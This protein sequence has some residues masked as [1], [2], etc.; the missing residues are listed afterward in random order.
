MVHWGNK[1]GNPST[2]SHPVVIEACSW[3]V[4]SPALSCDYQR[5]QK[6]SAD[7]LWGRTGCTSRLPR[8]PAHLLG[9]AASS[10]TDLT[11]E[12]YWKHAI[13]QA[14]AGLY[15][16][17]STIGLPASAAFY[18]WETV[19]GELSNLSSLVSGRA[20]G[21]SWVCQIPQPVRLVHSIAPLTALQIR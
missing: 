9:G 8:A 7:D 13:F 12:I 16:V 11:A 1:Q 19:S 4:N 15:V 17:F 14:C 18:R 10:L 20:W 3:G 21:P 6:L 5:M 2:N